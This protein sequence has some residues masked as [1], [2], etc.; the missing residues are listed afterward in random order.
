MI[1][2]RINLIPVKSKRNGTVDTTKHLDTGDISNSSM[3]VYINSFF[4]PKDVV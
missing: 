2:S 1:R 3:S 4:K